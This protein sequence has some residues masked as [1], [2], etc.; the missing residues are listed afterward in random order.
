M[1]EQ[2]DLI[3]LGGGPAGAISAWLAARDGLDVVLVDPIRPRPRIEGLG[4][5][6]H[7]W[8]AG[9]GLLHGFDGVIG[10]LGRRVDWAGLG[11]DAGG[12]NGEYL[13]ERAALD[14]HLR[15]AA[16]DAFARLVQGSG[17][18][19]PGGALL[20][21]GDRIAAAMVID[22]RGRGTPA[23][24]TRAP[25]TLAL[26]GWIAANLPPGIRLGAFPGGW[27]WRAA[28]P[29]GRVWVQV[30]LDA[31]GP[32]SPAERLCAAMAEGEPALAGAAL[33]GE[34]LV[35]EAAARLPDP[36]DDLS[37]LRVGDAFAAIDPL[38]GHGQFWA[39]SSALAVAAVR[40]TLAADPDSADICRQFLNRR[41]RETSLHQA[42]IGRDFIRLEDRFQG[43]PFWR[44]RREFPDDLPAS[45]HLA[46]PEIRPAI[47][48]EDG[49]LA[50]R[51]ILHTPR[52]PDG[53]G[54]FGA[55]P[56][57]EAWRLWR[58]GGGSALGVRWGVPA[59]A[60]L[61]RQLQAEMTP[62]AIAG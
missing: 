61:A 5:R 24:D 57:P 58:A 16:T 60:R 41:A 1:P 46:A 12:R 31:A 48:I 22:A 23:P 51:D 34:V 52:S 28:L 14:R 33:A 2:V 10:P 39:V 8:L 44:A 26:S 9:Q 20:A 50:R 37:V 6:L 40:R 35:R 27:L 53:I 21:G 17:R 29:D 38:S 36:V 32:G 7:R 4:P 15:R 42:R 55:V 25:A 47:V 43:A 19:A 13:V 30:M 56:A 49:L 62:A 11:G 54:W 3:V 59:A 45:R 18:P